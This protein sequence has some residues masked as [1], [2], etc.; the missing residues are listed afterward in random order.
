[1]LI[2]WSRLLLAKGISGVDT[3]V[4]TG[5]LLVAAGLAA[6]DRRRGTPATLRIRL[7]F[8]PLA[9]NVLFQQMRTAIPAFQEERFDGSLRYLDSLLLPDTPSFLLQP[10]VSPALTDIF[11]FF[12]ILFFPYLLFSLIY[13]FTGETRTLTSFVAGLFSLYG[14]GFLGYT[15]VPAA[16]PYLAFSHEFHVPLT[17]GTLTQWNAAVVRAGSSG[18]DVFPSLHVAVS[19]FLLGF[20]YRHKRWRFLIYVVPCAGLWLSTQYLRYHYL[21]DVIAGI[22]LAALALWIADRQYAAERKLQWT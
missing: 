20:D 12:Y 10:L 4:F 11:S 15:L 7:L 1:M 8:Y 21:I 5:C 16:G 18:V 3:L 9:M 19:G 13:Y 2:T 6:W 14:I 17:G 22:L